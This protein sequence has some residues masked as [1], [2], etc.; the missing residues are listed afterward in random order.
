SDVSEFLDEI[1]AYDEPFLGSLVND[2]TEADDP[3][4]SGIDPERA[5]TLVDEIVKFLN[6]DS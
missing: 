2:V 4:L 1:E 5:E 3:Q 6:G